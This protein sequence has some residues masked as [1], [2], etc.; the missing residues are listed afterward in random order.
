LTEGFFASSSTSNPTDVPEDE[1][2]LDQ[3]L[4][5]RWLTYPAFR[6]ERARTLFDRL[7]PELLAR[8]TKTPRPDETL[9]ALDGF[10]KGLPAG[11]Q[12]FSLFQSNHNLLDLL[13][14]I[15]GTSPSLA[16]YLSRNASV[17]DAVIA[18]DFFQDWKEGADLRDA[19]AARLARETDYE[20]K[21]DAARAWAKDWHF[22]IGVHH[23]R[24]LIDYG[25]VGVYY[26]ALADAV[27]Q[28][29]WPIVIDQ[30]A[31]KHGPPHGRG[32]SLVGMGSLGS[33]RMT[34]TSDLD[35]IVI[36]DPGDEEN[37]DGPRP[38]AARAYYARLTQAM[39]T[40]LSAPM[41]QGRLYE[42]DM[43]L[44]PSGNQGPVAT[45]FA[46]FQNYQRE[47]AWVWEHMALTRARVIVGPADLSVD[48]ETFRTS[49][50]QTPQPQ[51]KVL[52][53]LA[54]MRARIADAKAPDGVWDTKTGT[55]RLQDLD[56]LAQA[57]S[58]ISGQGTRDVPGCLMSGQSV[59]LLSR[60]E[61]DTLSEAHCRFLEVL[62]ATRLLTPG[63][64]SDD[65]LGEG[66]IAFLVR[67]SPA[68]TAED[69]RAQLEDRYE[70]VAA[71]VEA[72]L[73]RRVS[74]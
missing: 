36:Y 20:G 60:D 45:S 30:F 65:A 33:Q 50:L 11:V 17:F 62:F 54:D 70:R 24:G 27:I 38:L 14:D 4:I 68:E 19:L 8:V 39:I 43:R 49:L 53:A 51:K 41:S 67:A 42:V 31:S 28:A 71:I 1:P 25:R 35:M 47:E 15:A 61:I 56:L 21:L 12:I 59:N 52:D 48:I 6:S 18:G 3:N 72:V 57:T 69:L 55:G 9:A 63:T 40:A 32:A 74:S 5:A 73:E 44:R 2:N 34:A 64:V 37:S 26:T 66:G 46:S 13:V 16:A 29:L 23:L 22:R 58:L 7:R 10:L